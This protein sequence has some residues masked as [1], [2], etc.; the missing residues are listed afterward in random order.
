MFLFFPHLFRE[1]D[2]NQ[3]AFVPLSSGFAIKHTGL[4]ELK[5]HP[6]VNNRSG[7]QNIHFIFKHVEPNLSF[8]L[9]HILNYSS[10]RY[11][12]ETPGF[13]K[14][15]ITFPLLSMFY[16]PTNSKECKPGDGR[17]VIYYCLKHPFFQCPNSV[18]EVK[19]LGLK[20]QLPNFKCAY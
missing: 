19:G 4:K 2:K 1:T 20:V 5:C 11:S 9:P 8:Y 10:K 7:V 13:F 6:D 15:N 3:P 14:L 16:H 12:I 18:S 17:K